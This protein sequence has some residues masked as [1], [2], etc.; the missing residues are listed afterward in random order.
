MAILDKVDSGIL[1]NYFTV[2]TGD[3]SKILVF[4]CSKPSSEK[5]VSKKYTVLQRVFVQF[6]AANMEQ[7]IIENGRGRM[8][9]GKLGLNT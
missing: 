1:H 3:S 7:M 5:Q 4:H 2:I 9:R 8:K 6:Q